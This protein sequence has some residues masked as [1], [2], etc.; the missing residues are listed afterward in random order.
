[1]CHRFPDS[2]PHSTLWL[3]MMEHHFFLVR[4]SPWPCRRRWRREE[5]AGIEVKISRPRSVSTNWTVNSG[6][7]KNSLGS[8]FDVLNSVFSHQ[9]FVGNYFSFLNLHDPERKVYLL[10]V[11]IGRYIFK[12]SWS[13]SYF[14]LCLEGDIIFAKK[15]N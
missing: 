8:I 14:Y 2:D 9:L 12:R 1:M 4:G 5:V 6:R 3:C 11:G 7:P 15:R 10:S 13:W